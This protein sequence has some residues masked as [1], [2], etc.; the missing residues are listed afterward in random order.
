MIWNRVFT[1]ILFLW[2][3]LFAFLW[4]HGALAASYAEGQ[5]I[6][7][8]NVISAEQL[9]ELAGQKIEAQLTALGE[10]RRHEVHLQRRP[11]TIRLPAGEVTAVVTFP[12]GVPYGREFP[13]LCAVYVDGVLQRRASCYYQV[14]VY[15]RVL[16]AMTDI[17]MDEAITPA[18]AHIEESSVDTL[19][20]TT[21]TDF[22]R[23]A[24]RVAGRYI[25]KG[26]VITPLLLAMPRV[27]SAGSPVEL[28][29]E[30]GGI[31]I[32]AEGVALEA[33]RIGYV[34]R[35]RN[36]SSGKLMRGRVIDEK[37]VQIIA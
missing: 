36:A 22:S 1:A 2:S 21:V 16:V 12:R 5:A 20:E 29:A 26:M 28:V 18:N 27:V 35:V 15:D 37:T 4:S 13:V 30:S 19:P 10:P 7:F 6:R 33:G 32:R 8:P 24:G 25:R 14:T 23:L 3:G 17:R 9:A 31:T 11:G 34:I